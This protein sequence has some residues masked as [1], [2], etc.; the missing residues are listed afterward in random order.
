LAET[1]SDPIGHE[2]S[3]VRSVTTEVFILGAGTTLGSCGNRVTVSL[4][5]W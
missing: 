1:L 4:T 3:A 2:L 5:S